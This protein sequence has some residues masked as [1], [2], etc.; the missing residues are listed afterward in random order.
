MNVC[1]ASFQ[2]SYHVL[3][4]ILRDD[5]GESQPGRDKSGPYAPPIIIPKE[6]IGLYSIMVGTWG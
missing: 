6:Q 5:D 4:S 1:S 3:L 2:L